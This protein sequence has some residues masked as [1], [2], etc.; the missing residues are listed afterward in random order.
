MFANFICMLAYSIG[1]LIVAIAVVA[2]WLPVIYSCSQIGY[3]LMV[4]MYAFGMPL[5][6]GDLT[7]LEEV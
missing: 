4:Q 1:E 7:V 2:L 3:S 6:P 5:S